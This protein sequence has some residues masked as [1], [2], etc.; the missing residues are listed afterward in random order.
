VLWIVLGAILIGGIHDFSALMVSLRHDGTSIADVAR[1]VISR[2]AKI[3]FSL[4]IWLALI[5]VIAVFIYFCADTFVVDPRIVVPSL[6]LIPVAMLIGFMLYDLKFNLVS[7][8][9]L[10]LILFFGLIVLGYYFPVEAV[11]FTF[12]VKSFAI[13]VGGLQ[14]WSMVL[15]SYCFIASITPVHIL[16]QPRDYLSAFLLI[17]GI[18]FGLAGIIITHPVMQLPAYVGWEAP[19]GPLWPMLLVTVACGA[20]S[21]FHALIASGTSSKQL[22]NERDARKIGYGAMLVEGLLAILAVLIVGGTLSHLE[23]QEIL[24]PEAGGQSLPLAK[25]LPR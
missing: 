7:T 3:V 9:I 6:G 25:G 5:L 12:K 13:S 15:L 16:L 17:A 21:G 1:T 24:R 22:A 8:T 18:I 2:R 14:I 4:F 19:A 20:I 10:G 23:L 11:K